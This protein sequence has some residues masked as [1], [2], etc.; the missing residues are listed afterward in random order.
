M[1]MSGCAPSLQFCDGIDETEYEQ[2][3]TLHPVR[4]PAQMHELW[5]AY[6]NSSAQSV[7]WVKVRRSSG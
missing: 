1:L 5:R 4:Q 6:P 3:A 7:P 2:P